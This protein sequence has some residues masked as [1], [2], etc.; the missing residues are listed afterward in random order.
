MK[1]VGVPLW[2][3]IDDHNL[4]DGIKGFLR[5][6]LAGNALFSLAPIRGLLEQNLH[7]RDLKT[8]FGA[9]IVVRQTHQHHILYSQDMKTD[10]EL[11]DTI[12]ASAAIAFLMKPVVMKVGNR[13]RA[14][15]S[16]GGHK[17]V[18]PIPENIKSGDEVVAVSC[19]PISPD[20]EAQ[21]DVDGRIEALCWAADMAIHQAH[22]RDIEKLRSLASSGVKVTVYA[23]RSSYGG[24]LKADRATIQK[25]KAEGE[26]ALQNP[27]NF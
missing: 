22:D 5:P 24:L 2:N 21:E 4:V 23:P 12:E 7:L 9:G 25:R 15:A 26:W 27:V 14:I 11:H 10:K 1:S 19:N 17:H 16:D 18:F 20:N 13:D 3:S 8:S 6:V